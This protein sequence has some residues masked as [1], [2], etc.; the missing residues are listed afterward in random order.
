MDTPTIIIV[1]IC[2][3][4]LIVCGFL[5]PSGRSPGPNIST[6]D[7]RRR[8]VTGGQGQAAGERRHGPGQGLGQGQG[9][10]GDGSGI[11]GGQQ[12]VQRDGLGRSHPGA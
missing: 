11:G 6:T 12:G 1:I 2:F 9:P 10:G 5:L 4:I 7:L 3:F 8:R